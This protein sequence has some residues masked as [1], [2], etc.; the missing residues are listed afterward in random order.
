MG[1]S[2]AISFRALEWI[3]F[4]YLPARTAS[5]AIAIASATAI[6]AASATTTR[7]S[8]TTA[9]TGTSTASTA[10][11]A[12]FGA[13]TSFVDG[14]GP[15]SEITAVQGFNGC[16]GLRAVAHLDEAKSAKP[17]AELI[18]DKIHLTDSSILS[19]S[20]SQVVFTGTEGKIS[21]V[22]IQARRPSF[23]AMSWFCVA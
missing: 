14:N 3:E 12:A 11:I 6:S 1:R 17:A 16:T 20:L 19:K 10:A 15:P 8:A 21:N 18:A 5:A 9:A 22:D 13:R 2:P 23:R 7:T 4:T